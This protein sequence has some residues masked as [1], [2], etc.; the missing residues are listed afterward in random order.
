M[1]M[2][3]T[4]PT[5]I[6]YNGSRT[7]FWTSLFFPKTVRDDVFTLYAFVRVADD[8]VDAPIP[9]LADY[10]A[11]KKEYR[12]A[13]KK[14]A[15]SNP[16]VQAFVELAHRK[17]FEPQWTD[18][19]FASMDMDIEKPVFLSLDDTLN[20]IH[21]SAEVVGLMMAKVLRLPKKSYVGA[22]LLG[23]SMQYINFI[24]DI[25]EDV[26]LKRSYFPEFELRRF[27]IEQLDASYIRSRQERFVRFVHAQLA[28]YHAWEKQA[29]TSYQY[30]PRRKRIPIV[31]AAKLYNW[32]ARQIAKNPMI[33][34]ERKVKPSLPRIFWE[35][36]KACM[37]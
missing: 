17:K 8:Y 3:N 11:F 13:Q 18:A 15:I 30:I 34:Y 32:T 1:I 12:R 22:Q 36:G 10:Y 26:K 20:Y 16:I 27:G 5:K 7:Y 23:R 24:R 25:D 2:P 4:N 35:I 31:A 19:F 33:V 37:H 29:S 21:G 28:F 14:Q 6:F 9:K